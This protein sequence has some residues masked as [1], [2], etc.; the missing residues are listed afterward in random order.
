MN[1]ER[2]LIPVL[3]LGL[4]LA[5]CGGGGSAPIGSGGA[6]TFSDNSNLQGATAKVEVDLN[7][8]EAVVTPLVATSSGSGQ[9]FL[10]DPT[11][12]TKSVIRTLAPSL[13]RKSVST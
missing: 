13:A 9:V 8:G 10:I 1:T 11:T 6:F 12:G 5:G 3:G 2:F 4:L 7:T